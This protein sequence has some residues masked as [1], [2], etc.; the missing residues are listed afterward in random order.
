M[1]GVVVGNICYKMLYKVGP[2][3]NFDDANSL[4]S[5]RR[6]TLPEIPTQRVYEAILNYIKNSWFYEIGGN[7]YNFVNAWLDYSYNVSKNHISF[8]ILPYYKLCDKC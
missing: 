4:C 1:D 7:N 5:F 3:I 2:G 8:V 6:A